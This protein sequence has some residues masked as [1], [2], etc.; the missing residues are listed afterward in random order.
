MQDQ[1]DGGE[2]DG[3]IRAVVLGREVNHQDTTSGRIDASGFTAPVVFVSPVS[4]HG[5]HEAVARISRNGDRFRLFVVEPK[6]KDY[7]HTTERLSYLI[8]EEGSQ[9]SDHNVRVVDSTSSWVTRD[10]DNESTLGT[11]PHVFQM[12]QSSGNGADHDSESSNKY[13]GY[14]KTRMQIKKTGS[15]SKGRMQLQIEGSEKQSQ[16]GL[17]SEQVGLLF[18]KSGCAESQAPESDSDSWCGCSKSSH[19]SC[20]ARTGTFMGKKY[21]VGFTWAKS[22]FGANGQSTINYEQSFTSQPTL[23]VNMQTERGGNPAE[24]RLIDQSATSFKYQLDEDS[25]KDRESRHISEW[26]SYLAIE[27]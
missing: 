10:P 7:W 9:S 2:A 22:D 14:V 20:L 15:P 13:R 24:V 19:S 5:R 4:W 6:C 1:A 8:L 27:A 25:C 18:F 3:S 12:I 21:E 26:V 16:N 23:L 17:A 11:R